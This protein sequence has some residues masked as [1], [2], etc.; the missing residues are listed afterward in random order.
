[1]EPI[2]IV[3]AAAFFGIAAAAFFVFT[4]PGQVTGVTVSDAALTRMGDRYALTASIK[5]TGGADRLTAVGS[6]SAGA[7]VL[8]G[9]ESLA[10]P[11]GSSPS[12]SMDGAHAMLT[13]LHGGTEEGRLVP[14]SLWFEQAGKV[15]VRARI[16]AEMDM[17]HGQSFAVPAAEPQPAL[18]IF[19]SEDPNGWHIQVEADNFTFSEADQDGPHRPGIGHAHVYLNG[20]KLQRLFET[21]FTIGALP[22]GIHTLRVTLNTNDHRVYMVGGQPVAATAT[23]RAQ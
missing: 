3:L 15:T 23:I 9:G 6:D 5:N 4:D 21:E 12:L 14:V 11:A 8:A 1:M 20:L 18:Q 17:D 13:V 19:V 22:A 16:G 7:A 10:I 2:R